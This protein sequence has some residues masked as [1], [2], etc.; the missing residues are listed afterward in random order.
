[1]ASNDS[2]TA[3]Y[4]SLPMIARFL[5]QLIAG[6]IVGGIYRILKFLETKNIVTLV[7]GLLTT[8]TGVGNVIIWII[9]LITTVVNG[10]ITVFAD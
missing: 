5:I 8:F 4:D 1:M 9:D 10:K 3:M 2:I 7:V 6:V